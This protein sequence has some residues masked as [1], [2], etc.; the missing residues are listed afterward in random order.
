VPNINGQYTYD[1]DMSYAQPGVY[2][3][4]FGS[5][6]YGKIKKIIVK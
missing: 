2:I 4:R 6:T 5:D 3:I 1:I